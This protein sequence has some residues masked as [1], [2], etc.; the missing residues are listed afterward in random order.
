MSSH[1]KSLAAVLIASGAVLFFSIWMLQNRAEH[2]V[3]KQENERLTAD[4]SDTRGYKE[5]AARL[6]KEITELDAAADDLERRLASR[7]LQGPQLVDAIVKSASV[8]GMETASLAELERREEG[9]ANDVLGRKLRVV[10][11]NPAM[12]GSY[13]ELVTFLQSVDGWGFLHRI[14]SIKIV[15]LNR[16]DDDATVRATMIISSFS[17]EEDR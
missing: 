8:S 10:S 11:Y 14:E 3:Q 16:Q 12:E 7:S 4:L 6:R 2:S 17:M 1:L 5:S 13:D 9:V 15:A